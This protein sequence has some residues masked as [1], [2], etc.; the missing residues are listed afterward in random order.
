MPYI[1][2]IVAI[3]IGAITFTVLKTDPITDQ[4]IVSIS[5]EVRLPQETTPEPD[6]AEDTDEIAIIPEAITE[7][8]ETAT[9]QFV[10]EEP[11]ISLVS[12]MVKQPPTEETPNTSF[13]DG[14]YTTETAYFTPRRTQHVMDVTLTIEN[15][16]VTDASILWDGAVAPK[17]PSHSGF[18]A[19]YK[20][21]VIGKSLS[22]IDLSRVGGASLTSDAFNEAV[23]TIQSEARTS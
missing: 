1:I 4:E 2:A 6:T 22:M 15:D 17:T 23:D 9:V 13:V 16:V 11:D 21:E 8:D 20:E 5:E 18:D 3:A 7:T 14:S 12:E 10:A 19:A